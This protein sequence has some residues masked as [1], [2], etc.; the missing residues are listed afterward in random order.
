LPLALVGGVA[1]DNGGFDATSW[2]WSTLLPLVIVG[3]ALVLGRARSPNDL[4]LAFLGLL[5]AFAAWPA[6][7]RRR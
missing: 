1:L 3:V 2:G 7:T 5:C 4:A 6:S